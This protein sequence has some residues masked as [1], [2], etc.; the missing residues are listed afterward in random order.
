MQTEPVQPRNPVETWIP[1]LPTIDTTET[2]QADI[3]GGRMHNDKTGLV[4][5][6]C[7]PYNEGIFQIYNGQTVRSG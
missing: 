5:A 4:V 1:A 2:D 3:M 6:A 7:I